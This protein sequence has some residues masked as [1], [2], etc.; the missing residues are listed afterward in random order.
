MARGSM[1]RRFLNDAD[2]A[3]SLGNMGNFDDVED[4]EDFDAV[5]RAVEDDGEETFQ[6]FIDRVRKAYAK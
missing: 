3:E 6:G 5:D 2:M 1:L 4:D